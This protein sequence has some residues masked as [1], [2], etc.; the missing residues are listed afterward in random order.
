MLLKCNEF[1]LP[2]SSKVLVISPLINANKLL[3]KIRSIQIL[4]LNEELPILIDIPQILVISNVSK[5]PIIFLK[6]FQV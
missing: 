1:M 5:S 3:E 4:L 6:A 2:Q